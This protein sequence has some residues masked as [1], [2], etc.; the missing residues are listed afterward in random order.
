MSA[1]SLLT[2]GFISP[3]ESVNCSILTNGFID[4]VFVDYVP[5][6]IVPQPAVHPGL[7]KP[8]TPQSVVFAFTDTPAFNTSHNVEFAI[9]DSPL[10]SV[11]DSSSLFSITGPPL[12]ASLDDNAIFTIPDAPA[13][14]NVEEVTLISV[15][16]KS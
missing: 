8:I 14:M 5:L 4:F 16:K 1:I 10:N 11:V 2:R 12:H 15:K 7:F 13:I 3:A 6:F 9:A